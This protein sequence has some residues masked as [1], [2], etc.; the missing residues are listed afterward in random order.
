V[1]AHLA[2]DATWHAGKAQQWSVLPAGAGSLQRFERL[3]LSR[4]GVSAALSEPARAV[5]AQLLVAFLVL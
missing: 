2:L 1:L 3:D 4:S 5:L